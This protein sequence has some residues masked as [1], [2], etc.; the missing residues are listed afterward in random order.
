MIFFDSCGPTG[1]CPSHVRCM[2]GAF[3]FNKELLELE[4][5]SKS[6]HSRVQDLVQRVG[7]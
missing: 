4:P 1:K 2:G 6:Q 3:L 5:H 7:S